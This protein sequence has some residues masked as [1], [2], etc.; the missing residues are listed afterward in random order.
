MVVVAAARLQ[1]CLP[2]AAGSIGGITLRIAGKLT[3]LS[4]THSFHPVRLTFFFDDYDDDM[5]HRACLGHISLPTLPTLPLL[6]LTNYS[7][8]LLIL[9]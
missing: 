2:R 9:S 7:L 3:Y 6:N 8:S 4:S 5:I 1:G